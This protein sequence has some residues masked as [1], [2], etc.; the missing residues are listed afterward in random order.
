M[1]DPQ[2]DPIKTL[3]FSTAVRVRAQGNRCHAC[4]GEAMSENLPAPGEV[5]A[6]IQ[7]TQPKEL[8]FLA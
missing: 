7:A 2:A 8:E 3:G 1:Y 6:F 5:I 4:G